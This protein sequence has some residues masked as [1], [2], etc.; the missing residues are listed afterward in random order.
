[1]TDVISKYYETYMPLSS[2]K[3]IS[4]NNFKSCGSLTNEFNKGITI[5]LFYIPEC[6]FCQEFASEFSNFGDNYAAKLGARAVAVNMSI[7]GNN[8][9][10]H[11]SKN[12][13]YNL[14]KFW[15][16]IMVFHNGVP[17]SAYT[18]PR[19][20]KSLASFLSNTVCSI[21]SENC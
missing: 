15:P 9:L 2:V 11:M 16:T 18:G 7:N 6:R 3:Q 12:F 4:V 13:P 5:V 8:K 19:N 21:K 10:E 14:G 20:A 17:C 1:M